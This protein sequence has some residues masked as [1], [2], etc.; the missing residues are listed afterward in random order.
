MLDFPAKTR[1]AGFLLASAIFLCFLITLN[2]TQLAKADVQSFTVEGFDR[3]KTFFSVRS[4][5]TDSSIPERLIQEQKIEQPG[6]LKSVEYDLNGDGA[7]EKFILLPTS[8]ISEGYPWLIYN[9]KSGTTL[10]NINGSLVFIYNETDDGL[11]RLET[12]WK[13]GGEMAVVFYYVFSGGK[14]TRLNSRSLSV[15]E[16]ADYFRQK[17]PL[18]LDREFIEIKQFGGKN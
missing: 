8:S 14:Y 13:Q 16:I 4:A 5:A 15:S 10:G 9:Q 17:P 12:Y 11:P 6:P 2:L 1:V 3:L 7:K 18:D